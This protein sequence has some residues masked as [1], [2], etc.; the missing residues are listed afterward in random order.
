MRTTSQQRI[1][2][3][4]K[5][6]LRCQGSGISHFEKKCSTRCPGPG[7]RPCP[8]TCWKNRKSL[9]LLA[10]NSCNAVLTKLR[11]YQA[12]YDLS[13]VSCQLCGS[14]PD[15]IH[16]RLWKCQNPEVRK[17]R[18]VVATQTV[19]RAAVAAGPQSPLYNRRLSAHPVER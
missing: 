6:S 16:Q 13:D 11:T 3:E 10:A 1:Q 19:I 5:Y 12:G 17:A 14:H 8:L 7:I 9:K 18:E 4:N 2:R 15:T